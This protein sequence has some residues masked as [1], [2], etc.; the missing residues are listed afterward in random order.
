MSATID[1]DGNAWAAVEYVGGVER[2]DYSNWGTY[3]FK[4]DLG[5]KKGESD[6]SSGGSSGGSSSGGDNSSGS[7]GDNGG[8][9][10][11]DK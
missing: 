3:I 8:S 7:D 11:G 1:E 4:V 5:E 2:T 10:D 9:G 6:G